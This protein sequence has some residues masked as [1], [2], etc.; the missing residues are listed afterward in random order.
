MCGICGI[1]EAGKDNRDII[2]RMCEM[3]AHRGPENQGI[4]HNKDT[5]LGHRRLSIIDLK[6]GDQ[7]IYNEDKSVVVVFN[8]E[9][10]NFQS[11]KDRLINAGHKFHGAISLLRLDSRSTL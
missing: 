2:N 10:Y 8:G 3:I 4:Y 6:T 11:F 5:W 1:V 9:I 7:P